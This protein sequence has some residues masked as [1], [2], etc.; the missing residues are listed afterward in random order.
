MSQEKY[1]TDFVM[2]LTLDGWGIAE[3]FEGNPFK[4]ASLTNW[5]RLIS[6]FPSTSLNLSAHPDDFMRVPDL[7]QLGYYILGCGKE[8]FDNLSRIN[9]SIRDKSFFENKALLKSLKNSKKNQTNLHLIGL[10]SDAEKYSSYNHLKALLE[11]ARE[12]NLKQVYLHLFLDGVDT[13]GDRGITIIGELEKLLKKMRLGK[14]A[15]LSGRYYAMDR[16]SFWQERTAK[17]Y[18]A[19]VEGKGKKTKNPEN[20]IRESY[21]K[22]IFDKELIPTVVADEQGEGVKIAEGDS[23][24]FFN[25]RGDRVRQ[26][27]KAISMPGLDKFSGRKFI[28]NLDLTFFTEYE[29]NIPARIAF[30]HT[31]NNKNFRDLIKAKGLKELRLSEINKF[32]H[33]NNVWDGF[34]DFIGSKET[35]LI[36]SS[37]KKDINLSVMESTEK[38]SKRLITEAREK[39]YDFV[40]ANLANLDIS[41]RQGNFNATVKYIE[42]VDKIL[43]KLTS[44]VS[45]KNGTIIV[46]SPAGWAENMINKKTEELNKNYT[47]NPLPTVIIN[48]N[49]EGKKLGLGDPVEGNLGLIKPEK[50]LSSLHYTILKLLGL[51]DETDQSRS[52]I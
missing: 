36:Y 45:K 15:S 14:I 18:E 4:Q 31:R 28:K 46:A 26:L 2:F 41:A 52:L 3:E 37:E 39:N 32:A 17:T 33:V 23:L 7:S 44:A 10:I 49:L 50:N 21:E 47:F 43:G 11:L 20:A 30:P 27:A 24:I 12:N 13:P 16:N 8:N 40:L 6:S 5:K 42:Q 25:F 19:I 9:Q 51:S 35:S 29:K 48:S 38:I 1:K 22:Q 34:T